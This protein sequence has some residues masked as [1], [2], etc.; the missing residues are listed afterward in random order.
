VKEE[1]KFTCVATLPCEMLSV[2][3][4]TIENS[5]S[6]TT[7][8]KEINNRKQRVYWLSYCLK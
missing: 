5:T 1:G 3:E 4:A 7:R 6:V 2:L 8:F